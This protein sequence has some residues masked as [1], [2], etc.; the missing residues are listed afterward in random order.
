MWGRGGRRDQGWEPFSGSR[1]WRERSARARAGPAVAA[2]TVLRVHRLAPRPRSRCPLPCRALRGCFSLLPGCRRRRLGSS[3]PSLGFPWRYCRRCLCGLYEEED[4]KMA[5]LQMLLEEEIPGGRRALFDSY[6]NL[7]R[8][9]DYCE[10][11]YIQVRRI[12]RPGRVGPLAAEQRV[13]DPRPGGRAPGGVGHTG[14]RPQQGHSAAEPPCRGRS[15]V[16]AGEWVRIL[17]LEE[18]VAFK[19]FFKSRESVL[20]AGCVCVCVSPPPLFPRPPPQSVPV[21]FRDGGGGGEWHFLFDRILLP[22][23][24]KIWGLMGRPQSLEDF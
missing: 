21:N 22:H 5:E 9:A 7:E 4:V 6:T 11:N 2:V 18:I 10:N 24:A 12:C 19:H 16:G 3:S 15:R 1:G 13:G 14:P 20:G 8:V 17:R 23:M